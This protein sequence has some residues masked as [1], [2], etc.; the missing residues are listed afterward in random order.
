MTLTIN[1]LATATRSGGV[2]IFEIP[3]TTI[4]TAGALIIYAAPVVVQY[5]PTDVAIMSMLAADSSKLSAPTVTGYAAS[6][7]AQFSPGLST[8]AIAGVGFVLGTSILMF[9]FFIA[10]MC[11]RRREQKAMMQD[12]VLGETIERLE[13]ANS[14]RVTHYRNVELP[15]ERGPLELPV[16]ENAQELPEHMSTRSW[17]RTLTSIFS[18]THSAHSRPTSEIPPVPPVPA[19]HL[20]PPIHRLPP[21]ETGEFSKGFLQRHWRLS[22]TSTRS[23][24]AASKQNSKQSR[25]ERPP[26]PPDTI[27]E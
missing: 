20:L 8:S 5:Q 25:R 18:F 2:A 14:S 4:L 21:L 3:Q 15:G 16:T 7:A 9:A 6:N 26:S 13:V 17:R 27:K 24:R 11:L 12:G 19:H 22:I 23:F 10:F 1:D